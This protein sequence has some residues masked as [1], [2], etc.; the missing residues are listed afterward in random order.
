MLTMQDPND[1]GVYHKLTTKKFAAKQMPH[2]ANKPRFVVK[3]STAA[4]LNFAATFA[5]ASRVI[6]HYDSELPEL[7][8]KYLKAALKAWD[9]AQTNP[10]VTFRQPEGL[11]TK[12]YVEAND[13]YRDQ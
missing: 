7:S 3:K 8:T 6:Q 4:T 9:W 11:S 13:N 12:T 5:F 1:G 10:G 2:T